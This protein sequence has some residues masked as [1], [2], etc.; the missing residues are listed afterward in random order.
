MIYKPLAEFFLQGVSKLS[1]LRYL[2]ASLI[3]YEPCLLEWELVHDLVPNAKKIFF[4]EDREW[5][6][7]DFLMMFRRLNSELWIFD[8]YRSLTLRI[9]ESLTAETVSKLTKLSKKASRSKKLTITLSGVVKSPQ[10]LEP[11]FGNKNIET[12]AVYSSFAHHN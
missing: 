10:K 4:V 12:L 1:R 2:C 3:L 7:P 9:A 8:A 11:A 6:V 5:K